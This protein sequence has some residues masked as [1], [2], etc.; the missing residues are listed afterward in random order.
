MP[1][2][3]PRS[4]SLRFLGKSKS[5]PHPKLVPT[6]PPTPFFRK[7]MGEGEHDRKKAYAWRKKTQFWAASL[8]GKKNQALKYALGR[9]K[10]SFAL[11]AKYSEP[12]WV[13]GA[14]K[15]NDYFGQ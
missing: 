11:K 13:Q 12:L 1:A 9:A 6:P 4:C 10:I 5:G 8:F 7:K 15:A 3:A 14:Q 2:P